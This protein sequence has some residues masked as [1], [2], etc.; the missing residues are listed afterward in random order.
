MKNHLF[1]GL[2]GQGGR[3]LGELRK[4]MQ[5]RERDV[6]ALEGQAVRLA[7]LAIDSSDD[8]RHER[9]T[10][11]L[12]GQHLDLPPSDWLILARPAAGSIGNLA[13]RA[14]INPWIGDP[15]MGAALT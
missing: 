2:G 6:A 13:V 3:T 15:A 9:A 8:V 12:F 1:I 11:S 7:F 10:W 14:D 5:Q 4:V